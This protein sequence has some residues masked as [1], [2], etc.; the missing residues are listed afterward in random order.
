MICPTDACGT[1]PRLSFM[2]ARPKVSY[3]MCHNASAFQG[4]QFSPD[5][6]TARL[7][8]SFFGIVDLML[9]RRSF[10]G[11]LDDNHIGTAPIDPDAGAGTVHTITLIGWLLVLRG[12][13][14]LFMP[15]E[16]L[17]K[18]YE[19]TRFEQNYYLYTAITGVLSLYL[20]IAGW[21]NSKHQKLAH[22]TC[23]KSETRSATAPRPNSHTCCVAR[24]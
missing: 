13:V 16:N 8:A 9:G 10:R 23:R 22:P 12:V 17:V 3:Q 14:W 15:R 5:I 18:Y 7:L 20:T 2:D 4:C 1:T 19:A 24:C 11:L 21:M 6:A